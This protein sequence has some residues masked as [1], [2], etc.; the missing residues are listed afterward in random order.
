MFCLAAYIALA[1]RVFADDVPNNG[2]DFTRPP[3]QFDFRYEF[4]EKPGDVW[5]D[6]FILRLNRPFPLGDGW[7][8]GTRLDVPLVLTNKSS[9][10]N[11]DGNDTFGL[12]DVLVQAVLIDK[13]STR[14][15]AGLGPRLILPTANQDQFGAAKFN[16]AQLA[17]SGI[18]CRKF[19]RDPLYS[20]LQDTIATLA[21]S[22]GAA[23]SA[24]SVG[25]RP[26]ISICR[27]NGT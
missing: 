9:S 1:C 12:R 20:L 18:H 10:D 8:I 15:A 11:P 27:R 4:E 3:A 24:E 5:Q 19:Q 2:E 22:P 17:V 26:L 21:A 7:E 16:S 14:W 6:L 13:L 25:V 23:T